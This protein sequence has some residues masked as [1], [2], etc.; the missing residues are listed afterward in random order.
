MGVGPSRNLGS[1]GGSSAC[2]RVR[3]TAGALVALTLLSACVLERE[4]TLSRAARQRRVQALRAERDRQQRE[5]DILTMREAELLTEIDAVRQ[6]NVLTE[7]RLR[8]IRADLEHDL[9]RLVIAED[10]LEAAKKR[11]ADIEKELVPL[12]RLEQ[13]IK[14][15]EGLIAAAK[16]RAELLQAEL[17]T[18]EAATKKLQAELQPKIDALQKE[19][20]QAQAV[21]KAIN[22]AR[23]AMKEGAK[24]I[25]P[26]PKEPKK[27]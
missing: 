1:G 5:V 10:D 15:R 9:G 27:E 6:R 20:A 26:K 14:E 13:T 11:A 18:A 12:R 3:L 2:A 7:A 25:A 23:A 4:T 19:L 8:A 17:T 21:D 16:K 22:D 24:L